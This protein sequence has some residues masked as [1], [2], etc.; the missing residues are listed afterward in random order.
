MLQR[1]LWR[2][3]HDDG[4]GHGYGYDQPL[5]KEVEEPVSVATAVSPCQL[6]ALP[7][8][9]PTI[10]NKSRVEWRQLVDWKRQPLAA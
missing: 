10:G 1:A 6:A 9:Q 7:H 4:Y 2:Q 8:R 5:S 3:R